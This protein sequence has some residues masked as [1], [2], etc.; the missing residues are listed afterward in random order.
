MS[1]DIVTLKDVSE[2]IS[3]IFGTNPGVPSREKLTSPGT[4]NLITD[5]RSIVNMFCG[6]TG[7]DLSVSYTGFEYNICHLVSCE[8]NFQLYLWASV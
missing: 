2:R 3:K 8:I 7:V 5:K 4:L 1:L 6:K